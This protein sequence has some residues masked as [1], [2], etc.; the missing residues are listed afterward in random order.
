MEIFS[1]EIFYDLSLSLHI[2]EEELKRGAVTNDRQAQALLDVHL[3]RAA[4]DCGKISLTQSA[5]LADRIRMRLD[6]PDL[7]HRF[8]ALRELIR[9]EMETALFLYIP[10]SDAAFFTA[11]PLLAAQ[12]R[13]AFPSAIRDSEEAGKCVALRRS[14]AC[15][16]HLM[17]V[18]E[19]GLKELGRALGIP[20]APSWESYLKQIAARLAA[21]WKDKAPEW[22]ADEPFYRDAAAQLSAVKLAW[23]NPTMHVVRHYD[24]D[25]AREIY[26]S[27]S[28]LMRHL[29]TKLKEPSSG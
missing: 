9:S 16:F 24:G 28:A 29:A 21:E 19:V 10:E 14:T 11:R 26:S 22:K 12:A 4:A 6:A 5:K 17:R 15:V 23:R 27:V 25:E 1:A 8:T 13:D 7:P 2:I 20:Y 3:K 18:V